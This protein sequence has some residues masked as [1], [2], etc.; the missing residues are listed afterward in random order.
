MTPSQDRSDGSPLMGISFCWWLSPGCPLQWGHLVHC[1]LF[2][3]ACRHFSLS[4]TVSLSK[5]ET[6]YQP[7]PSKAPDAQHLLPIVIGGTKI[8][9]VEKFCYHSSTLCNSGSLDAEVTMHIEKD[10]SAFWHAHIT[11]LA[12]TWDQ[13]VDEDS[14]VPGSSPDCTLVL[15]W[16]MDSVLS[17]HQATWA[18]QPALLGQHLWHQKAGLSVQPSHPGEMTRCDS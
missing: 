18:F 16:N 2:L 7:A 3:T 13:T 5:T 15:L 17:P 11:I 1:R 12:R 8:K 9:K 14:D 10:S 4:L 6:M